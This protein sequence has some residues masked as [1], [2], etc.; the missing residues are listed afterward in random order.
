VGGPAVSATNGLP[1]STTDNVLLP[2]TAAGDSLSSVAW[3]L[4]SV[5]VWAATGDTIAIAYAPLY[6]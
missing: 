1:F 5:Y 2:A 6:D 4:N 3:N